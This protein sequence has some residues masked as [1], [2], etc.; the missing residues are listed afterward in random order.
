MKFDLVTLWENIKAGNTD[1]ITENLF[2][3]IKKF[4]DDM[5]TYLRETL[6]V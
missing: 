5:M 6:G 4:F 2:A 1:A 3:E